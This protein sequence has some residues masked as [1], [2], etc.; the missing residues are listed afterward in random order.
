MSWEGS[1][2]LVWDA[3]HLRIATNA[4]GIGLWSWNVDTDEIAMDE[5]AHALWGVPRDG[6]FTFADLS[7]HIVPP[8]LDWVK[9][10]FQ[11]TRTTP[12]PYQIDFRILR[13][14]GTRWVSARGRGADEGI[15]GRL[16]FGVFLDSTARK[17]AEEAREMLAGE[18][19]HRVKN[20]FAIA[21]SLTSIAA[22]SAATTT[23]MER[24]LRQRLATLGRAH[25]LIRPM[26]GGRM[27]A[28]SLGDLFTVLL[29]PYDSK[30]SIGD[31][32]RVS[33]PKVP[34]GEA[35]ATAL[36]LIIH[37]L[38]TNSIKYGSLSRASGTLDVICTEADGEI[39]VVWTERGGPRVTAPAGPGGFGSKLL[40]LSLRQ[41][42]GG[43]IIY[44]WQARGVVVVLR[45]SKARL[46]S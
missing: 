8:N 27:M 45:M 2:A 1:D 18:I 31:R 41:Q 25:D 7:A 20:L 40:D 33:V 28:A 34:V 44:D 29:A 10:A 36:A 16:M 22:R 19:S 6:P 14:D 11:V 37:E 3:E 43:S 12:G 24:D 21:A 23:E 42:L 13:P 4:A 15:V 35:S 26:S 39:A 9:T 17:E 5:R 46:V 30:G 38:A 32:I